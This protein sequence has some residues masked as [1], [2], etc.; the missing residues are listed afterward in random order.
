MSNNLTVKPAE[1]KRDNFIYFFTQNV[2]KIRR[3][4]NLTQQQFAYK[5]GIKRSLLGAIE[6]G[7]TMG[8]ENVYKVSR[9]FG[10]TIDD[11]VTKLI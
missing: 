4:N 8:L 6:E 10:F 2:N 3:N 7:R 5:I 1:V 11:L 9:T